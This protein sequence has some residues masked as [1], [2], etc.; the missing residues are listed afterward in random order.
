QKTFN[1]N[2]KIAIMNQ[3]ANQAI[4]VQPLAPQNVNSSFDDLT[5]EQKYEILT[6]GAGLFSSS[7]GAQETEN[8]TVQFSDV[9]IS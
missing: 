6:K 8:Q 7:A 3:P 5:A 2:F 1:K 4:G 9:I